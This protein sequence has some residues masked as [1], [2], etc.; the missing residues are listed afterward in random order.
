MAAR[1]L[2][3]LACLAVAAPA[4]ADVSL[5]VEG[6]IGGQHLGVARAPISNERLQPMGDAGAALVLHLGGLALGAAAE[7]NFDG[8]TLQRFNGS[9]LAGLSFEPIRAIRLELLGELGAANLRRVRDLEN[10]DAATRTW[11]PFYGFRPGL[12]LKLPVLPFRVGVWGLA[13]WGLAG[14][15]SGPELGLLGRIGFDL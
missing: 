14:S 4:N 1:V 3:A 9:A 2:L 5:G 11:E 12:S 15:G 6:A 13:R 8:T 10:R 7:G